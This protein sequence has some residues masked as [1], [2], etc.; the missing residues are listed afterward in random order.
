MY[1]H[2]YR[3]V[4][5]SNHTRSSAAFQQCDQVGQRHGHVLIGGVSRPSSFVDNNS[6]LCPVILS[7]LMGLADP[8]REVYLGDV[9]AFD[10]DAAPVRG[11]NTAYVALVLRACFYAPVYAVVEVGGQEVSD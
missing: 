11:T 5:M 6:D 3:A 9:F 8:S 4:F 1:H 7:F 10:D 2:R